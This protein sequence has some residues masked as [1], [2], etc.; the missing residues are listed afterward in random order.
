MPAAVGCQ[1]M[2]PHMHFSGERSQGS[3][4]VGI[5]PD[6]S[7]SGKPFRRRSLRQRLCTAC[8]S[9]LGE[10]RSYSL[11]P[12]T[13]S[14]SVEGLAAYVCLPRT[15]RLTVIEHDSSP[16]HNPRIHN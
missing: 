4:V 2:G 8:L 10:R 16:T 7:V 1:W 5:R 9:L 3:F 14:V 15:F 6:E 11:V 13:L 12:R